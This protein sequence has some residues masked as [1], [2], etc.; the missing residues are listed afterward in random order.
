MVWSPINMSHPIL[1][2]VSFPIKHVS[3]CYCS[4]ALFFN[5]LFAVLQGVNRTLSK[6]YV[7]AKGYLQL[8]VYDICLTFCTGSVPGCG[9]PWPFYRLERT[10]D[11]VIIGR[12]MYVCS[13][14]G[15]PGIMFD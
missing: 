6:T 12:H 10:L 4:R 9:I 2:T 15:C 8:R 14:L 1:A 13:S 3:P 11:L 7:F 5:V